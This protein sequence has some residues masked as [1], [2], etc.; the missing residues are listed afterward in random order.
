M[1]VPCAPTVGSITFLHE[2]KLRLIGEMDDSSLRENG[3]KLNMDSIVPESKG[4]RKINGV[5]PNIQESMWR[6]YH[7][8][9]LR[10]F[11]PQKE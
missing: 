4:A 2:G 9:K 7:W 6:C 1:N 11:R 3:S 8:S 10:Q 5:V